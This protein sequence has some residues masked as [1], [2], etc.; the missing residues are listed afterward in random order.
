M[1]PSG[2]VFRGVEEDIQRWHEAEVHH[3]ISL[4]VKGVGSTDVWRCFRGPEE[5]TFIAHVL[6]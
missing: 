2:V 1:K 5:V 3:I 4:K 6:V